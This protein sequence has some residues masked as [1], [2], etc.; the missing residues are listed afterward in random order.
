MLFLETHTPPATNLS[1]MAGE[2]GVNE[3]HTAVTLLGNYVLYLLLMLIFFPAYLPFIFVLV[4]V[5]YVLTNVLLLSSAI[6]VSERRSEEWGLLW[7]VILMPLYKSYFK[8][9]RMTS[10]V[11]EFFRRRYTDPYLPDVVWNQAPRW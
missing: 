5:I 7:Y 2:A 9:V 3:H 1:L 4:Y 6:L 8:W 10:Y 11:R